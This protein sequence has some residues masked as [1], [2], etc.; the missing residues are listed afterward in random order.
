M[1]NLPAGEGGAFRWRDIFA[2]AL[3]HRRRLIH[4]HLVAIMAAVLA[5]PVPLL[6]PLLVDE[7]LLHQP[8][9][10]VAW[11]DRALPVGWHTPLGYILGALGLTVLLRVISPALQVWQQREFSQVSKDL[12]F[13]LRQRLLR[14]LERI[15]MA[16]Y[17]AVGGGTVSS[18]LVVDLATIDQFTG[19]TLSKLLVAVLTLVGASVV[20]LWMHWQLALFIL[21]M[22]PATVWLTV[23]IARKTKQL[24]KRENA[25]VQAFQEA[26]TETLE[27]IHQLRA[28]HRERHYLDNVI[29]L[30][31]EIRV[32]AAAFSWKSD[33]AQRLS[34][35][36]FLIGVDVFRAAA[37][38][39]VVFSDLTLGQ[40]I[41]VF[42][43]LWFMLGPVDTIF[44]LQVSW[45]AA[46]AALERVNRLQALRLEPRYPALRDPF[47]GQ[48]TV[49]LSLRDIR[50]RYG[51][52]PLVLDGINLDIARGERVAVVGASGGGKSTL[53]QVILGLYPA[54]SGSLLFDGVPV[55]EIGFENVRA[56]VGTV[57]QHP[58]LFN[59][60]VRNNLTLGLAADEAALW[61]ALRDAELA[62][63]VEGMP[64]G[65]DSIIGRDGIRL[66]GGQRQRLAIARLLLSDPQVVILDE[67]TSALDQATEAKIHAALRRRLAGRTMLIVAHRLSAVREADRVCVFDDGHIVEHGHHEDLLLQGGLYGRLYGGA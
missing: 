41:A 17:E 43:Y 44:N 47:A 23:L 32:H 29:G 46:R 45:Q 1:A 31:R 49:A 10:L 57:L 3:P 20:L 27:A 34:Y 65:L 40:M 35:A 19:E 26:L 60:S 62:D 59:D 6:M 51:E 66:S 13:Q 61:S 11:L 53:V 4:A 18:H 21:V 14:R 55:T 63:F 9:S 5:V 48:R 12:I 36:V 28:A 52:G 15:S 58:A 42:G 22:N 54:E 30:A 2:L 50:F 24:K 16:E 38:L 25:A 33:A 56:N 37:M 64:Q 7:V 67:A 8:G 39:M